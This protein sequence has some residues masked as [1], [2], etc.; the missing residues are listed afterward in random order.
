[1]PWTP[2]FPRRPGEIA[3]ASA[4]DTAAGPVSDALPDAVP[5]AAD[6]DAGLV[7]ALN[8]VVDAFERIA[9]SLDADRRER[10]ARL[11]AVE[12]LLRD[13]VTG[14]SQPTAEP[15][16]VVGGS[17]DLTALSDLPDATASDRPLEI[18]RSRSELS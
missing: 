5:D 6:A 14:L 9:E 13:L 15:P 12:M 4:P 16:I 3:R 7:P 18:D 17:I 11:D 1:M 8:R 10:G 2:A